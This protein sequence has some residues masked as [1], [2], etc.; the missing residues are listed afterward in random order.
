MLICGHGGIGRRAGLRIRW[1]TVQVQLLLP[2]PAAL[3]ESEGCNYICLAASDMPSSDI[4]YHIKFVFAVR[5]ERTAFSLARKTK[6]LTVLLPLAKAGFAYPSPAPKRKT[7]QA[8]KD[9]V[10]CA[11]P[12]NRKNNT[13]EFEL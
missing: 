11:F 5:K 1:A 10:C 4:S 13:R 6:N 7:D 3:A 8:L 9:L 12:Q 2:A